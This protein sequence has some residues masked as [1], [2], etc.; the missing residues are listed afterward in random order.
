MLTASLL[1][2]RCCRI[3]R[4]RPSAQSLLLLSALA[5][6]TALP[7]QVKQS[8][9]LV[10]F[11]LRDKYLIVVQ[12]T[13]NGSG[14]F[15]FLLDTGST[16]TV[17][18]P[19]LALQLQG[20]VIGEAALTT[21]SDVR[22]D[23]LVR[24]KEIRVGN[25]TVSELAAIIDKMDQVKLKAPG[26]R[27]V[28]GEDFISEFDILI[29]YKK[30][31]LRFDQPAPG[32]ERCRIETMGHYRGQT[33]TNRLL[34]NVEFMGVRGGKAQLQLDTGAKMPELFPIRRDSFPEQPWAGSMAFSS[35]PNGTTVHSHATIRIGT[36]TV[37]DLDVIQSR[38][39]VAFDAVGLLPAA[40]FKRIYIS[41]TGGFVV[42][43]PSE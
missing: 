10:N 37:K 24:L 16:H 15:S 36:T 35:G 7:A 25:S 30:R 20:P 13:V 9:N 23:K 21:V 6:P 28:L 1:L 27:G 33:T 31:E 34:I 38:R 3:F 8:N 11:R 19:G 5:L 2:V 17:I 18:D 22:N 26:V 4:C 43:N 41:H 12:A 29:D 39:G 42:L 40:I 14:P 32:G